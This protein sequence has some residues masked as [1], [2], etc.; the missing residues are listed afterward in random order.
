M[1]MSSCADSSHGQTGMYLEGCEFRGMGDDGVNTHMC[2]GFV[3]ARPDACS[4]VHMTSPG[5][6][7]PG[8]FV[9]FMD[10]ATGEMLGNARIV[11]SEPYRWRDR[12][13][14]RVVL[15][16]P[17][18]DGVTTYDDLGRGPLSY[19]ELDQATLGQGRV[20]A[21]PTHFYVPNTHGVGSV[22]SGCTFSTTRCAGLVL[23]NSNTLVENCRVENAKTGFRINALGSFREGTPSQNVIVRDCT[24]SDIGE[25][26][27]IVFQSLQNTPPVVASMGFLRIENCAFSGVRGDVLS[28]NDA[29][30]SSI[31]GITL[32]GRP[33]VPRFRRNAENNDLGEGGKVSELIDTGTPSKARQN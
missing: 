22:I 8:L 1:V 26:G 2:G 18:P 13:C 16:R 14:R 10:P 23:Q 31:S 9:Q 7:A 32:D 28:L 30:D 11:S 4:F 6:V 20:D 17:V 27:V 5:M 29:G 25:V 15:D 12:Q 33:V 24:F 3:C 19:L 21:T